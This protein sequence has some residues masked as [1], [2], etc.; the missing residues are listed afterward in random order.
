MHLNQA[1][2]QPRSKNP[3]VATTDNDGIIV[4]ASASIL[5]EEL[6]EAQATT[7]PRNTTPNNR[8]KNNNPSSRVPYDE[9]LLDQATVQQCNKNP[10]NVMTDIDGITINASTTSISNAESIKEPR[11]ATPIDMTANNYGNIFN[12]TNRV[13]HEL[14]F[15]A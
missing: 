6:I 12:P 1:T 11:S 9:S 13:C 4:N 8:T 15:R 7:Q 3:V 14:S 5:N 10:V 2:A